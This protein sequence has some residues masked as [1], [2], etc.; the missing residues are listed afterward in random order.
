MTGTLGD[1]N[2]LSVTS[3]LFKAPCVA[4]VPSLLVHFDICET[5]FQ[6]CCNLEDSLLK[7]IIE[8]LDLID[9]GKG[10]HVLF[11]IFKIVGIV[12][13]TKLLQDKNI[14]FFFKTVCF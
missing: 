8:C 10:A 3:P 7:C 2:C 14:I 9:T 5:V 1:M 12:N 13:T 4:R 6:F 11:V